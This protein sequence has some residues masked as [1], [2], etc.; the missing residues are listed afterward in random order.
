M[1]RLLSRR[2]AAVLGAVLVVGAALALAAALSGA[3]WVLVVLLLLQV[4][5]LAALA[6]TRNQI[7]RARL[8]TS[9]QLAETVRPLATSVETMRSQHEGALRDLVARADESRERDRRVDALDET[10]HQDVRQ[11]FLQV[12]TDS[13]SYLNL[14]RLVEVGGEFPAAG[15]WAAT[16][17]TLLAMV[18]AVQSR[19]GEVLVVECGS[20]TST[21]W[22]AAA[23]RQR[24]SG[25]VVA[26]EHEAEFAEATREH[27]RRN[28]LEDWAEVRYAPLAPVTIG[29]ATYDWYDVACFEDLRSIDLLFVDGPPWRTGENARYPAVPVLGER[30]AEGAMVVLDDVGRD[31]ERVIARRWTTEQHG[32]RRLIKDRRLDRSQTFSVQV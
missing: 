31:Q 30:L 32:T 21:I 10:F 22:L 15:G 5:T 4:V 7:G 27:L 29:E 11:S 1:Q 16:P 24:G 14:V 12:S 17:Q 19:E 25:R 20:G 26:V 23:M 13:W 6:V 3:S 9:Q 28:H 2:Q 8:Q 18:G